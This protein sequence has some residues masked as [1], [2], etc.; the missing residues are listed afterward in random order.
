VDEGS[1]C[2]RVDPFA[3]R[4]CRWWRVSPTSPGDD[5]RTAARATLTI[6]RDDAQTR[7]RETMTTRR[8]TPDPRAVLRARDL[9]ARADTMIV[10]AGDAGDPAEQMRGLCL[11]ALRAAGAALAVGEGSTRRRGPTSAWARL[12]RSVPAFTP[13]ATYFAGL[14]RLRA[15]IEMGV[16]HDVSRDTVATTRSAVVDFLADVE[17]L[18]D[19][20]ARGDVA[21][22]RWSPAEMRTA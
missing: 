5:G 2:H 1:V 12:P 18:V 8:S 20:C 17:A 13:W 14:S 9:L 21:P 6:T 10:H 15:D 16:V 11:A 4:D 19:A 22:Q 3:G 7:E